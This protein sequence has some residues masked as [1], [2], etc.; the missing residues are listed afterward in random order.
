MEVPVSLH[1]QLVA[2]LGAPTPVPH[3][4]PRSTTNGALP[5]LKDVK[6]PRRPILL[7]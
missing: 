7:I 5:I 1:D 4:H 6:V 3:A 2:K